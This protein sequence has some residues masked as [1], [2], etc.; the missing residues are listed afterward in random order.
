MGGH[1]R[2]WLLRHYLRGN[3]FF[4][5]IYKKKFFF[6]HNDKP[7]NTKSV[8]IHKQALYHNTTL[9]LV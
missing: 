2:E 4:F 3:T 5:L 6:I 9:N 1:T 8:V 7:K